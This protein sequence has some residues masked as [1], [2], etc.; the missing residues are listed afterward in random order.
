[1][2]NEIWPK[3]KIQ[4]SVKIKEEDELSKI[5]FLFINDKEARRVLCIHEHGALDTE[6][7]L[8]S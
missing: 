2:V 1:M 8:T 5:I 7:L 4:K 6:Y 3:N